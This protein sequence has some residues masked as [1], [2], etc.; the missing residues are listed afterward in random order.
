[1]RVG[2]GLVGEEEGASVGQEENTRRKHKR[3]A[4]IRCTCIQK[5]RSLFQYISAL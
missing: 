5:N 1:M 2:R 4:G 3:R